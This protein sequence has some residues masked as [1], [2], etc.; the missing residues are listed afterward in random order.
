M[1]TRI[2]SI[3]LILATTGCATVRRHPVI[4]SLA[5]GAAVGTAVALTHRLGHC[6]GEY[7]TGDPPCPPPDGDH[8]PRR[9]K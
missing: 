7:R 6:P 8:T 4:F 1:R 2:V 9:I 3:A 5:A